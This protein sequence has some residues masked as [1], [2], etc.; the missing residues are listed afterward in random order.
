[1]FMN[2]HRWAAKHINT[3]CSQ[4]ADLAYGIYPTTW[5]LSTPLWDHCSKCGQQ[6]IN[7]L[8]KK[9]QCWKASKWHKHQKQLVTWVTQHSA[10]LIHGAVVRFGLAKSFTFRD[11]CLLYPR[12]IIPFHLVYSFK[13]QMCLP[14]FTKAASAFQS[15]VPLLPLYFLTLYEDLNIKNFPWV[16]EKNQPYEISG[17][18]R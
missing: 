1:M 2:P 7:M 5:P 16:L 8:E 3:L 10:S 11:S 4:K 12:L 15:S 14:F 9:H 17:L 18:G 6:K 13:K